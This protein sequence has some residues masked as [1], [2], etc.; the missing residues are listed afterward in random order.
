VSYR[1]WSNNTS[2]AFLSL[3][4]LINTEI[5]EQYKVVRGILI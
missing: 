1:P 2:S 3:P 4:F 5:E